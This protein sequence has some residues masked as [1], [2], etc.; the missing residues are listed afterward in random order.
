M[1]INPSVF[2]KELLEYQLGQSV[3][4]S[5]FN[6]YK[7]AYDRNIEAGRTHAEIMSSAGFGGGSAVGQEIQQTLYQQSQNNTPTAQAQTPFTS[8]APANPSVF[9][10]ELLEY[11]LGESVSP[12]KFEAYKNAYDRNIAAG[13]THAEIMSSAGFG[14]GSDVG[15]EIQQTL[16][17]MSQDN[18]ATNQPPVPITQQI[19][20]NPSVFSKEL[21]EYQLGETVS[22]SKFEAYK[23]A[24]D[25][26]IGSGRTHAEI[27]SSAGF[28][29]N[30]EAGQQLQ[31]TL[32]Q[33]T[34][35]GML[36]DGQTGTPV[37]NM[38][39]IPPLDSTTVSAPNSSGLIQQIY[40]EELGRALGSLAADEGALDYWTSRLQSGIT[41]EQLR[42][43]IE[44]GPEGIVFDAYV[45]LL[46]REPDREGSQYYQ[47]QLQTGMLTPDQLEVSLLQS[48]EFLGD[49]GP[50]RQQDPLVA[51]QGAAQTGS[52]ADLGS[53]F[54]QA[55]QAGQK[56]PAEVIEEIAKSRTSNVD[57][58]FNFAVGGQAYAEGLEALDRAIQSGDADK[59][60]EIRNALAD[61]QGFFNY[62][63]Q[64]IADDPG[65]PQI[66]LR[67][68][69]ATGDV[70]DIGD[71][72]KYQRSFFD[73]IGDTI[74]DVA[75]NP[76]V[77][78][79]VTFANPAAGA[80]LN[81]YGTLDS[82][83]N[84]S[85]QQI[86]AA[87]TGANS[88]I[89]SSAG[90]SILNSLPQGVQDFAQ[91]VQDFA[92]GLQGRAVAAL[93]RAF[94]NVDTEKLAE[95][96][97]SIKETLAGGEDFIREVVGDENIEAISSS[98][99]G[100]EDLIRGQF[101]SQQE[102]LDALAAALAADSGRSSFTPQRGYQPGLPVD[103]EF[104][105]PERSSVLD[106]LN[107]PSSIQ[108]T[109]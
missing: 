26:N 96:E 57:V 59:A 101:G 4:P 32:Y 99:A 48:D 68:E 60:Q 95:Y 80:V 22:P 79:A 82:G 109:S 106:I 7:S 97:D 33:M 108:R 90:A 3:S 51:M 52:I 107:Q 78:A 62:Y 50:L 77:Q 66:N 64:N 75:E 21:L 81:A 17:Q 84:L 67:N 36:T 88:L 2:S 73:K 12:S 41:P 42:A 24:Y 18:T 74:S 10:K 93:K 37:E 29:G 70:F 63:L 61:E 39:T 104:D 19:P 25:A 49:L 91:S 103:I 56:I 14:G 105:Q 58:G 31:Q 20:S 6:A 15:K 27:M 43:E 92:N 94:P 28:G 5:K 76:F 23:R 55:R 8:Q 34:P 38:P 71:P 54:Y 35:G 11:Q 72:G 86:V 100:F 85:P 98:L 40:E 1:A 16:Y 44:G 83:E 53:L 13:R 45:G 9:S 102:Q 87:A 46:G 89:G 47:Q 65:Q 30:T 69:T